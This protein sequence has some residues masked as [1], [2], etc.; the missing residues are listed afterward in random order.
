MVR[1]SLC[2]INNV[3]L[4]T[5]TNLFMSLLKL[6]YL[7]IIFL[8][9]LAVSHY[10]SKFIARRNLGKNKII[11]HIETLSLGYDKNIYII[12]VGEEYFLISSTQK[13]ICLLDKLSGDELKNL[14][15]NKSDEGYKN[16]WKELKVKKAS[17]IT[18]I[19]DGF[20]GRN[21]ND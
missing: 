11:K 1:H 6:I 5:N 14:E 4:H 9:I 13:N 19:L 7:V 17:I 18:R 16:H 12:K 21:I 2:S 20:R 3:S 8:L 10:F 15:L